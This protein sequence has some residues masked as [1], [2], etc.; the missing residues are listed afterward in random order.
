M[1]KVL[2]IPAKLALL[3]SLLLGACLAATGQSEPVSL[4]AGHTFSAEKA[5]S[6]YLQL[7]D[8]GLDPSR[9]YRVRDL[10][11]DRGAIH[12]TLDD[13]T[14][15]F[16]QDV[17]GR[18]T[19]AFF[20]GDGD[21]LL[22]PPNRVERASMALFTGG[23]I[24]E[25]KFVSAYFRFNDDTFIKLQPSLR[26]GEGNE[27]AS[28][29]ND[30]A[31]KL[32]EADALRI[33]VTFSKSLP[34]T[35]E[36]EAVETAAAGVVPADRFFHARLQ[37]RQLG[38]FDLY[39]DSLAK[40]QVRAGQL[41]V[42]KDLSYYDTWASFSAT[43]AASSSPANIES[44]TSDETTSAVSIPKFTIEAEIRPPTQLKA[45]AVLQMDVHQGGQRTVVFELSRFLRV[46]QA[47]VDGSAAG[48][49]HNQALEGTRLARRGNDL[50]AVVFPRILK[51]GDHFALRFTYGGDVLSSAGGGLLYVGARGIWYPNLGITHSDFDMKFRFPDGWTLL[52]TGKRVESNAARTSGMQTSRWISER[53]MPLAGFNLGKYVRASAPV[54]QVV[55]EAYATPGVES[56]FPKPRESAPF[57]ASSSHPRLQEFP[58]SVP[59]TAA[60]PPAPP[61]PAKNAQTVAESSEQAIE[62]FSQRFGPYPYSDLKLT[63]MPGPVSQG[64]PGLVFLST[65]SYLTDRERAEIDMSPMAQI[66]TKQVLLHETAHQWWGDLVGWS[67]YRDQWIMEAL[68][69]YSALLALEAKNPKQ[70]R[71]VLDQYR[72]DLLEKN[73]DGAPLWSAGPVTLGLRLSNSHFPDGYEAISYGRGTWLFHMLRCMMRDAARSG[74]QSHPGSGV[75]EPFLRTLRKLRQQYED[76]S[77]SSAV[78]MQSFEDGLPPSLRYEGRKSLDW[79]YEGWVNGTAIPRYSLTDLKFSDRPQGTS[80]SGVIRQAD[81]PEDLVTSLP[82]YAQTNHGLTLLGRVFADGPETTFHLNAPQGTRKVVLDPEQT[83]LAQAR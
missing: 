16:T 60:P 35:N 81:A 6:L 22:S 51:A 61:S 30:T 34:G 73:S 59:Y 26:P 68:A 32:S 63:Q 25:E 69:N 21:V 38:D 37:G 9:V 58:S 23:A 71:E 31:R 74:P 46:E 15:G 28:L 62:F 33:F 7:Q 29:W 77:I 45:T 40:E 82:V 20:E 66:L 47:E 72:S 44:Q 80:V 43:P 8:L 55:V 13:G 67:T 64:W 54:G 48:F 76:K 3:A 78:L 65:L 83:V 49:I 36:P 18:V 42:V 53:P 70:F 19:G 2:R 17:M 39:F 57:T 10:P 14:I 4:P 5:E 56:S 41:K 12:I 79:F 52:A 24:L 75:D 27:F 11:I 50:V 1:T